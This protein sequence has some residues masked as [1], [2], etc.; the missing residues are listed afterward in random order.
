MLRISCAF[1]AL[2][3]LLASPV[4]AA[5][6]TEAPKPTAPQESEKKADQPAEKKV[7]QPTEKKADQPKPKG[8]S[9]P[10]DLGLVDQK[11]PTKEEL[12]APKTDEGIATVGMT[13]K[14]TGKVKADEKRNLYV[15]VNPL[16]NADNVNKWYVQ[17]AVAR[18]GESFSGQVQCGDQGG[19]GQGEYFAI[20][21]VATDKELTVG[22]KLDGL[23]EGAAFSK[24]LIVKRR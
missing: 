14:C 10:R 17:R 1:G 15:V 13:S 23:P 5:D 7:D 24:L 12:A 6:K 22:E 19:V 20:I 21:A 11:A 4:F 9:G 3:C 2:I 18:T 8:K 16:S